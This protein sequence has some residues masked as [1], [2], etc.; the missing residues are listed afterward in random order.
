MKN[1]LRFVMLLLGVHVCSAQASYNFSSGYL[2]D[3][4]KAWGTIFYKFGTSGEV[5]TYIQDVQNTDVSAFM[6]AVSV[7]A[8]NTTA[9]S[10]F[11]INQH[12]DRAF[13]VIDK[14]ALTRRDKCIHNMP[15][16]VNYNPRLVIDGQI[17]GAFSDYD[18]KYNGT[19]KTK[20]TGFSINAKSIIGN[21][22]QLGAAYTRSMTDTHDTSI[23]ADAVSNSITLFS[24]YLSANGF[25]IN[26]GINGG[27]TSWTN[28]KTF[29]GIE[30]DSAYD[31][32]F[33][34]GQM[35]TGIHM[36]RGK[37]S[38]TP[39]AGVRYSR[40]I[41]DKYIDAAAQ[42]FEKWWYNSLTGILGINISF[43]FVG[44]DFMI[45]PDLYIV[46]TY[47]AISNGT[48]SLHV[49]LIDN[50]FY[51]IPIEF[52]S[53]AAF[54]SGLGLSFYGNSFSAGIN[55]DLDIRSNYIANTIALNLKVTF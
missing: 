31:T 50:Q 41:A 16:C 28:D 14:P 37:I 7:L 35:V 54:K 3:A 34:S 19:F 20:N 42:A 10:L 29:A 48:E 38:I 49:Q 15:K 26:M 53:R 27:H 22:W 18:S 23:Y 1:I 6:N 45:K 24:E 9:I 39:N 55:Y 43:D 2:A 21:A 12:I 47:D 33:F 5:A 8:F 13:S 30:D 36:N 46:G 44:S 40:V 51:N 4:A 25:F 11:E 32:D 52:P 17:F